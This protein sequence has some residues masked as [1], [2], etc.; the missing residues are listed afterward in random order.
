MQDFPA[1]P[2]E[3]VASAPPSDWRQAMRT[4]VR[5]G[6]ELCRRLKL[7]SQLEP[8]AARAERLFPVFAPLSYI[9]RMKP[10]DPADPLLRQVLPLSAE[11]DEVAGF[12]PDP[13]GDIA[14]T[15]GPRLLQ[16]YS[17]RVLLVTT[18]SCAVH[19][20]YCF[21]REFDYPSLLTPQKS[22]ADSIRRI[23]AD[24]SIREV[25]LSGGDPLTLPDEH[26][27]EVA[28]R[29]SRIPHLSRLRVHSRLP[30]VIPQRV[31]ESLINWLTLSRL[32]P[33]VVI[34]ANHAQ[35]LDESVAGALARLVDAGI[36]VLNQA[37]LLRGVNDALTP[38]IDLCERLIDLRVIPYYLHQLDR[39]RGAAHFEV[40]VAEGLRLIEQLRGAL[41]GYAVPKYV[42]E[43]AGDAS[44]RPLV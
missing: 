4:A 19:C 13:V 27:A 7:P 44:K 20:R 18:G 28:L 43:V 9:A 12:S 1:H 17:G 30:V 24:P 36:P 8:A 38:L 42:S 14:A 3:T 32:T 41:P 2:L 25:I 6:V 15:I 23:D 31:V 33:I 34:H 29:L 16:K 26:L 11:C 37:V 39:V 22:L 21:R 10:G 5:S 35:E 40:P